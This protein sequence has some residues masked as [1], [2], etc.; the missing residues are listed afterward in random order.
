MSSNPTEELWRLDP[1]VRAAYEAG[2]WLRVTPQSVAAIR[3]AGG[4]SKAAEIPDDVEVVPVDNEGVEGVIFRKKNAKKDAPLVVW[5]HGGGYIFG[6]PAMHGTLYL[7][8]LEA[9]MSLFAPRYRLTPEHAFPAAHDDGIKAW[10]WATSGGAL[11]YRLE[12]KKFVLGGTSAGGGLASTVAL[13]LRDGKH[14]VQPTCMVLNIPWVAP[15]PLDGK[16]VPG[17]PSWTEVKFDKIWSL[18]NG[19]YAT[20][21]FLPAGT[22]NPDKY[23]FAADHPSLHDLP[24]TIVCVAEL[25]IL[26]DSG[27]NFAQRIMAESKNGAELHVYRGAYHGSTGATPGAAVSI[28]QDQDQVRFAKA[29]VGL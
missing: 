28:A 7:Q 12:P 3:A 22:P 20:D 8:F 13:R 4:V 14:P 11:A 24:K 18:A 10:D 27:I 26:R 2:P 19:T 29:A 1:E 6:T 16:P 21:I 17:C 15:A 9:G 23:A 25:D 5:F